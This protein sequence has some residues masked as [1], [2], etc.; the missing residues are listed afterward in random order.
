MLC[1]LNIKK[2]LILNT[3]LPPLAL[4]P[5]ELAAQ[6]RSPF[7]ALMHFSRQDDC[8]HLSII[9]LLNVEV[10]ENICT[11]VY[12]DYIDPVNRKIKTKN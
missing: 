11:A 4:G 3:D 12:H 10:D 7:V 1:F 8:V 2:K 6:M 9:D 5:L